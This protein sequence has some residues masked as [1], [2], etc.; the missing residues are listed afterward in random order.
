MPAPTELV[1]RAYEAMSARDEDALRE[2]LDPEID[3]RSSVES[4]RGIEGVFEFMR[5][6]DQ[7]LAGFTLSVGEITEEGEG[8]LAEVRQTGRGRS[9]GV[10]SDLTRFH[11]WFISDGRLARLEAH[12][13]RD[14]AM[15]ALDAPG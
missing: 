13:T 14:A 6:V 8:V 9:S 12:E 3:W 15:D 5:G 10:A 4:H 2:L 11:A 1:Q 7:A